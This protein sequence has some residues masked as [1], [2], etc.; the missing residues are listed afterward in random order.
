MTC[1]RIRT[2]LVR[3]PGDRYRDCLSSHPLRKTIDVALA[4]EQHATY[5]KTLGELGLE[6][7]VMDRNDEHPDSCFVE[8]T[9]VAHN[10]KAVI[11]R[12]RM[13]SRRGEVRSVEPVLSKYM[14]TTRIL[15]PAT[16]E[17]G[18]VVHL[19]DGLISGLSARTNEEGVQQMG[20]ALDV[21]VSTI[22]DRSIMHLKSYISYLGGD[23]VL[24]TG[25]YADHPVLSRFEKVL[26]PDEEA[27]AANAVSVNGTV[28]IPDGYPKTAAA[29]RGA[30]F[31]VVPLRMT[32]FP[33]CEGAMTCLSILF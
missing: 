7:V 23:T 6:V 26:V 12:P 22:E 19:P 33:K 9:A 2:A 30:G 31:D 28:I 5:R 11:C 24:A 4:R 32:E 8:D 14:P 21:Q 17:G 15:A 18:D 3:E 20:K 1:I 10:G 25:R 27:Y 29:I 16:L 13:E